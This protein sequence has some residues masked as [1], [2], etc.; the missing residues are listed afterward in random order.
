MYDSASW[1]FNTTVD[2][3]ERLAKV[4]SDLKP[5]SIIPFKETDGAIACL[6]PVLLDFVQPF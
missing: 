6:T 3:D 5:Q 4:S 1:N 2:A